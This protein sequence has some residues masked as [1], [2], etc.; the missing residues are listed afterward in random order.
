MI[1]VELILMFMV[2]LMVLL[3]HWTRDNRIV[4]ILSLFIIFQSIAVMEVA[5]SV[6]LGL[7]CLTLSLFIFLIDMYEYR[8]KKKV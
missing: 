4:G 5:D 6:W 3:R 8:G 7:S 2:T 1:E